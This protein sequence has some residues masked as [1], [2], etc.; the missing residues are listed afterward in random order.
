MLRFKAVFH[1]QK[2]FRGTVRKASEH[3]YLKCLHHVSG[4]FTGKVEWN[5]TFYLSSMRKRQVEN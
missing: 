3:A 1:F 4:E 5:S 2:I